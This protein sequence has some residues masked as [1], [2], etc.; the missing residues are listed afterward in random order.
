[1][2]NDYLHPKME[3]LKRIV[4]GIAVTFGKNCEVVLHDLTKPQSSLVYIEGNVTNRQLGAPITNLILREIRKNGDDAEDL[5]CYPS[6]SRNGRLLKSSSI[7][8]RDDYGKIIGTLCINFDIS[9]LTTTKQ[10]LED[11]ISIVDLGS[12]HMKDTQEYFAQDIVEALTSIIDEVIKK[13]DQPIALMSKEEKVR[14]AE[15]LDERGVF[16]VKGSIDIVAQALGV[17]KY[18]IY[19]YLEEIRAIRINERM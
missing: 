17:S 15:L 1:M 7:F 5:L 9:H 11:L 14:V 6:R 3:D 8:I 4:K 13:V 2:S 16:L 19:N 12:L 10:I 18:T